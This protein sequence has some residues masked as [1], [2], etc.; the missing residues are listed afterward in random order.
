VLGYRKDR[1]FRG[2]SAIAF[3][4]GWILDFYLVEGGRLLSNLKSDNNLLHS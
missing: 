2:L 3:T 4:L 1:A